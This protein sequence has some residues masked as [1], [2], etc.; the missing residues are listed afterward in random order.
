[1]NL[2]TKAEVLKEIVKVLR[3]VADEVNLAF[4]SKGVKVKAVDTSHVCMVELD[5]KAS[6]FDAYESGETD[7]SIPLERFKD[8]IALADK[9]EDIT[10]EYDAEKKKLHIRYGNLH[11][12]M[13]VLDEVI[14]DPKV[15]KLDFQGEAT[16]K[17]ASLMKAGQACEMITDAIFFTISKTGLAFEGDGDTDRVEGTIDLAEGGLKCDKSATSAFPL[18]YLQTLVKQAGS[19][20][21]TLELGEDFP[22]RLEFAIGEHIT[23]A[24][25]LAPRIDEERATKKAKK[26]EAAAEEG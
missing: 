9:G 10:L 14:P 17:V 4:T 1:M 2:E 18:D 5:A 23:A 3:A 19:E 6:A 24:Y 22:L 13:R 26:E 25:I 21:A 12:W 7:I 16:V 20:E 8:A 11:R 15:P